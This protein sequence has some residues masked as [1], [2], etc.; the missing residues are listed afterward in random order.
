MKM[1][2]TRQRL[3]TSKAS[4]KCK[5]LSALLRATHHSFMIT[6]LSYVIFIHTQFTVFAS[7]TSHENVLTSLNCAHKQMS[8]FLLKPK[9]L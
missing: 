9:A 1:T 3:E 6:V 5:L 8:N 7:L 4:A 2:H